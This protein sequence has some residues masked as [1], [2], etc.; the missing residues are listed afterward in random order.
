MMRQA[1][2]S[3]QPPTRPAN[4][5]PMVSARQVEAQTE[6][7]SGLGLTVIHYKVKEGNTVQCEFPLDALSEEGKMAL[8]R[9]AIQ[10]TPTVAGHV[11]REIEARVQHHRTAANVGCYPAVAHSALKL[12][13]VA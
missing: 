4:R 13:L 10:H 7:A 1:E 12:Q 11:A 9:S 5:R 2:K 6:L 3:R 8:T